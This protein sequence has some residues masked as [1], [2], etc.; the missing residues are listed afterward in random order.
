MESF[1]E[2]GGNCRTDELF[3]LGSGLDGAFAL[4]LGLGMDDDVF[5]ALLF[6]LLRARR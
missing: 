3:W 1:D 4:G 6:D 5:M 2:E